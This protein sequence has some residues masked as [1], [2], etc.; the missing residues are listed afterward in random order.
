MEF[1]IEFIK[2]FFSTYSIS[3][4]IGQAFGI[5]AIVFGFVAF[6]MR[7]RKGLLLVQCLVAIL[8]SI[9]YF[10]IGAYSGTAVN[11]ICTIRNIVYSKLPQNGLGKKIVPIV[12]VVIQVISC[13]L[14]WEAW[15]SLFILLGISINTY[16]MSFSNPQNV[17][18]S[19]FVTSPL[20]IVYNGFSKS[21]GGV[22][23]ETVVIISSIIGVLRNKKQKKNE[24]S[25]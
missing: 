15:Y 12:F 13:I 3:W 8:F 4:Y 16:C 11:I 2:E 10:L 14:T 24:V 18:K 20:V 22:I 5:L 23:Y 7:T 17:R 6:Q 19:I 9:H 1:A 21:I 25:D